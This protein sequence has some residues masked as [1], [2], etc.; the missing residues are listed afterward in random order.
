MTSI[1]KILII[2]LSGILLSFIND[3]NNLFSVPKG[4]Q[5]P[6]YDFNKN[7]LT[8]EK[9]ELGRILFYDPILSKDN[10]ILL[11]LILS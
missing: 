5:Q 10:T 6:L 2:F 9:I 3:N 11:N 1:N 8:R 4:W 7:P